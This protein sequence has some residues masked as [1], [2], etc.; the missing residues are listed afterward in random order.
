MFNFAD[1]NGIDRELNREHYMSVDMEFL[2]ESS[3]R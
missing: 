3:A 1:L 2:F